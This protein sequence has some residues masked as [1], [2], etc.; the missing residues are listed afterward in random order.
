[1]KSTVYCFLIGYLAL[2]TQ[3]HEKTH[4]QEPM[5][6]HTVY[7]TLF[8]HITHATSSIQN[9]YNHV[10]N[11]HCM[12]MYKT[13]SAAYCVPSVSYRMS[14]IVVLIRVFMIS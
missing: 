2:L 3:S 1:M 9:D 12:R 10:V 7:I 8:G 14:I 11:V 5:H 13:L 6:T 4:V